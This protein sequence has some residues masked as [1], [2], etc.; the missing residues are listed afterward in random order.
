VGQDDQPGAALLQICNRALSAHHP[1]IF[2][3]RS[4]LRDFGSRAE[5]RPAQHTA[6]RPEYFSLSHKGHGGLFDPHIWR[7]CPKWP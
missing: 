2:E 5:R 7:T 6:A 3:I 1:D 4:D